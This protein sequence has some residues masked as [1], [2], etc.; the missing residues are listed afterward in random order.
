MMH[1]F[2]TEDE[3]EPDLVQMYSKYFLDF[4]L[5]FLALYRQQAARRWG[6]AQ[7]PVKIVSQ[8]T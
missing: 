6:P 8:L 5:R 4:F 3:K 2:L 1:L 7:F